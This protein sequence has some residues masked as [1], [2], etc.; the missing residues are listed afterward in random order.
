MFQQNKHY[1][2]YNLII[3]KRR[4]FQL[5]KSIDTEVHHIIPVCM[6]GDNSIDNLIRLTLREHYMMHLLLIYFVDSRSIHHRKLLSALNQMQRVKDKGVKTNS[7]LY[8]ALKLKYRQRKHFYISNLELNKSIPI[9]D[10][11]ELIPEGWYKGGLPK[12]DK[13][14]E[15]MSKKKKGILRPEIS[16]EAKGKL[17]YYNPNTKELI[18]VQKNKSIPSGFIL[19][20]GGLLERDRKYKTYNN[21][22]EQIT[23]TIGDF[24]P[25]GFKLG[26]LKDDVYHEKQKNKKKYDMSEQEKQESSTRMLSARIGKRK[27]YNEITLITKYFIEG[28]Q[29]EGWLLGSTSKGNSGLKQTEKQKTASSSANK[30]L[31]EVW[32]VDGS[33]MVFNSTAEFINYFN[34]DRNNLYNKNVDSILFDLYSIKKLIRHRKNSQ[35]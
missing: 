9:Y 6:G 3:E 27:Y 21:G 29:P 12:S 13:W 15:S 1:K 2:V 14:K 34:I 18:Q 16:K 19:G 17:W 4:K 31:Q 22:L 26:R 30:S 24:I 25:I 28:K 5:E 23:I 35:K 8:A 33:Y 20:H 10:E 7:R 11:N 32:L